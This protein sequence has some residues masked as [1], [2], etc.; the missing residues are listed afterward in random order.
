MHS[1]VTEAFARLPDYLGGHVAVSLTALALGLALSLPLAVASMSRPAE[2]P[3]GLRN[4]L[5]ADGMP[6]G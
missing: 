2:S 4:T 5:P 3:S 1:Q 6:R